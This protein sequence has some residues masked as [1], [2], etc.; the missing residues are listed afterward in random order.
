MKM[1]PL[2]LLFLPLSL[3][4]QINIGGCEIDLP[5]STSS[6]TS[7]LIGSGTAKIISLEAKEAVVPL[8]EAPEGED[9]F[10][11]IVNFDPKIDYTNPS[12]STVDVQLEDDIQLYQI[13]D[14]L[15]KFK[16]VNTATD[17]SW[18][19]EAQLDASSFFS[20]LEA[21]AKLKSDLGGGTQLNSVPY[22]FNKITIGSYVYDNFVK[23]GYFEHRFSDKE[24]P[25]NYILTLESGLDEKSVAAPASSNW[26]AVLE[27]LM[28]KEVVTNMEANIRMEFQ[29]LDAEGN[30]LPRKR[31]GTMNFKITDRK[32]YSKYIVDKP[33]VMSNLPEEYQNTEFEYGGSKISIADA[34][35]EFFHFEMDFDPQTCVKFTTQTRPISGSFTA[36]VKNTLPGEDFQVNLGWNTESDSGEKD[37]YFYIRR[38]K[39][40]S[41]ETS[42]SSN[43]TT[44]GE[45]TQA[46][47]TEELCASAEEVASTRVYKVQEN[48]AQTGSQ[49][50]ETDN[51]PNSNQE[52]DFGNYLYCL[53]HKDKY[54]ESKTVTIEKPPISFIIESVYPNPVDSGEPFYLRVKSSQPGYITIPLVD[55]KGAIVGQ[56]RVLANAGET[57]VPLSFSD[58]A[59]ASP[60][61]GVYIM[62]F[63]FESILKEKLRAQ[64]KTFKIVVK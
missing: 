4:A 18:K 3:H 5:G 50:G 25:D 52:S 20:S 37:D 60:A 64:G 61:S 14:L 35:P 41:S 27:C 43:P 63:N 17:I 49:Y 59:G 42:S 40:A 36:E 11:G 24:K 54:L 22:T 57:D 44:G 13:M 15:K 12:A 2:I 23:Y 1:L 45:E 51:I 28:G 55:M 10:S 47:T 38:L 62:Q 19:I 33:D 6:T 9:P 58:F 29:P 16:G 8:I 31:Y 30:A 39:L 34:P 21:E 46:P 32:V 53:Y 7:D 26:Q 56:A 48:V